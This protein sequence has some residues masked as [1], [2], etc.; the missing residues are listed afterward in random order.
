MAVYSNDGTTAPRVVNREAS[1][2]VGPREATRLPCRPSHLAV[3]SRGARIRRCVI[4]PCA[5]IDTRIHNCYTWLVCQQTRLVCESACRLTL[6]T[7]LRAKSL[8]S[9]S[10]CSSVARWSAWV[11]TCPLTCYRVLFLPK[12]TLSHT[13]G[14]AAGWPVTSLSAGGVHS[15]SV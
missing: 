1:G 14:Y 15:V 13:D 3:Q 7:G 10:C 11:D 12:Q 8:V 2:R 5:P 6:Q 9:R 4:S